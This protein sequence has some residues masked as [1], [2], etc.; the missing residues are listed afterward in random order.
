MGPKLSI[1]YNQGN[2]PV[3]DQDINPITNLGAT[4]WPTYNMCCGKGGTEIFRVANQWLIYLEI[5]N[6]RELTLEPAWMARTQRMDNTETKDRTKHICQK[7]KW[8]DTSWYSAVLINSC[9]VQLSA[10]ELHQQLFKTDAET[11][12]SGSLHSSLHIW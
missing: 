5:H 6:E 10:A 4:I 3:E 8:N 2:L 11:C 1:L 9:L 12:Q 7:I